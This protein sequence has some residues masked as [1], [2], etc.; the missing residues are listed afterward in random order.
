MHY[1][2]WLK[3]Y[4]PINQILTVTQLARMLNISNGIFY[5]NVNQKGMVLADQKKPK[6]VEVDV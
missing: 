6:L 2:E 3:K 5:Y 1:N 4:S